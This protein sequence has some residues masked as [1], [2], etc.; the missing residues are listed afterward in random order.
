MKCCDCYA[1]ETPQVA[2][3]GKRGCFVYPTPK[4]QACKKFHPA[5]LMPLA[6]VRTFFHITSVQMMQLQEIPVR[7]FRK[8]GFVL[9]DGGPFPEDIRPIWGK[10]LSK[11]DFPLYGWEKNPF[12]WVVI[13]EK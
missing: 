2:H 11:T 8:D 6:A 9:S 13:F 10:S 7:Q 5:N 12:I 3:C 1:C 4:N